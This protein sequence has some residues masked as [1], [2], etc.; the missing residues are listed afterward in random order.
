MTSAQ[1]AQVLEV[2]ETYL[3]SHYRK[4]KESKEKIGI[5]LYKRGRGKTADFG[6]Q[7]WK[8]DTICWRYEDYVA[9][10]S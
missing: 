10:H 3:L 6:Y 4:I 9:S 5:H 1:L 7:D 2:K 8:T